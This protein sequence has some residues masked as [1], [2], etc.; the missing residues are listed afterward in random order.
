MT[1]FISTFASAPV[2]PVIVIERLKDAV[3]LA[4]ALLQ[5]GLHTLEVTLRTPV[6]LA[7]VETIAKALPE[8][9]VGIGTATKTSDM[10][11]AQSAGARFAVSPGF[12]EALDHA[13][14]AAELPFLPGVSNAS[15]ILHA[16]AAGKTFV[17]FFPA[18]TA[19]GIKALQALSAPFPDLHFCPTGGIS[20]QS[21]PQYLALPQVACVGGSWVLP[22]DAIANQDWGRIVALA[23]EAAAVQ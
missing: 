23:R 12:T 4:E 7:A 8:A 19:G 17:K 6:A 20:L 16:L 9:Y 18:E 5:G 14:K 11:D 15:D 3:P 10:H 21:A 22:R 13:A 2:V 1:C